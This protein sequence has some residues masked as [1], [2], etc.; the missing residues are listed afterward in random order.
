MPLFCSILGS[1]SHSPQSKGLGLSHSP[2]APQPHLV[3]PPTLLPFHP[4]SPFFIRS[5]PTLWPHF[6][7]HHIGVFLPPHLC[8]KCSSPI[9]TWL[10]ASL[11]SSLYSEITFSV[12][13]SLVTLSKMSR[14]P[15]YFISSFLLSTSS[16]LIFSYPT[17]ESC[18]IS[19]SPTSM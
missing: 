4:P 14:V 10:P 13:P 11:P 7:T 6:Q 17:F 19:I 15:G 8:W 18:F 9:L 16:F 2:T 12:R 3:C 5:P 1:G